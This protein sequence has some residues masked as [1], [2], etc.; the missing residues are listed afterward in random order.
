MEEVKSSRKSKSILGRGGFFLIWGS[1]LILINLLYLVF[2]SNVDP[3][4]IPQWLADF[5]PHV[6]IIYINS[7]VMIIVISISLSKDKWGRERLKFFYLELVIPLVVFIGAIPLI[8]VR[9]GSE[10][11]KVYLIVLASLI[12]V[13]LCGLIFHLVFGKKPEE[14]EQP[15][16]SASFK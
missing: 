7:V 11:M 10:G 1:V 15:S 8:A 3:Q 4:S 13:I 9:W 6:A 16:S 14:D 5:P 2:M 12:G